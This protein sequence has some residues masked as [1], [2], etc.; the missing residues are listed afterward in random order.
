[1]Q[2]QAYSESWHFDN[3]Y[4]SRHIKN[5]WLI[6]AYSKPWK[7]LLKEDSGP[8]VFLWLLWSFY[9]HL[10]YGTPPDDCFCYQMVSLRVPVGL[11]ITL[12]FLLK[13]L[14]TIAAYIDDLFTCSPSFT[15]CE[16]NVKPMVP[17]SV[18]FV[19]HSGKLIF[20]PTKCIW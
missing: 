5:P 14:V 11:L 1:M 8:C 10:F 6:Q 16:F 3:S 2:I 9:K 7:T 4:I 20:V 13:I 12:V 19:A 18:E 17:D 15:K